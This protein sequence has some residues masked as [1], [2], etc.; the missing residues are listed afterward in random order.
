MYVAFQSIVVAFAIGGS[1]CRVQAEQGCSC[2]YARGFS[3]STSIS[4]CFLE[5]PLRSLG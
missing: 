2:V 5:E 4:P 3:L 1:M